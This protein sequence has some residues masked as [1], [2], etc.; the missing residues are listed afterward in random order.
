MEV[1]H[2]GPNSSP[3][4]NPWVCSKEFRIRITEMS[5]PIFLFWYV[6]PS[7][8]YQRLFT[9]IGNIALK[10]SGALAGEVWT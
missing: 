8:P 7:M 3:T 5:G 9:G 1:W 6:D 4:G 2:T 10:L